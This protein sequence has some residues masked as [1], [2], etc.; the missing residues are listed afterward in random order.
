MSLAAYVAEERPLVWQRLY[1]PGQE[2]ARARKLECVG[3][4]SGWGGEYRDILERK[5]G[6]GLT[7]EM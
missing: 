7:F 6:K 2:N 5:L 1:A 3:W 4:G